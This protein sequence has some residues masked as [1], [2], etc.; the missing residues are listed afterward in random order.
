MIAL[1][2]CAP[3]LARLHPQR[4]RGP[5][6]VRGGAESLKA[7][8]F[9]SPEEGDDVS[10]PYAVTLSDEKM[11]ELGIFDGDVVC[12]SGKA[13]K[14]LCV[15][16][17]GAT[18]GAEDLAG[19]GAGGGPELVEAPLKRPEFYEGRR[20]AARGVLLHGAPGCGKTSIARA[21]A[22]ETGAYFF[23]IN[24]AEILSKQAGEAE[25][26]LRKA[27]DEARKHAPSLI[28]LDEVDAIAPRSDG[29]KAGG[30]ERPR[31]R[32]ARSAI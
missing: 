3:A 29:K 20:R 23:L 9:P 4:S 11:D 22:A 30:D 8:V 17:S 14:T 10:P 7:E 19:R 2:L 5:L 16:A 21:V 32:S 6:G 12:V 28:F 25:A 18:P 26:N 1:L 27:F 31:P 13:H 24:G 15:A